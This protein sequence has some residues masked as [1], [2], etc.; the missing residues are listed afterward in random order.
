MQRANK[1]MLK[2]MEDCGANWEKKHIIEKHI[3]MMV[4]RLDLLRN[5]KIGNSF[6]LIK[7]LNYY[8]SIKSMFL[9]ICIALRGSK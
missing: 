2:M 1:Q 8:Q 6:M 4:L 5:R 9:E 3:S 7:Y